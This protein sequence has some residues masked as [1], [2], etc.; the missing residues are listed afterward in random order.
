MYSERTLYGGMRVL[1][2]TKDTPICIIVMSD[3]GR[4][5][6]SFNYFILKLLSTSLAPGKRNRPPRRFC[7]L[8][9]DFF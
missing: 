6:F 2:R 9:R 8:K 1:K 7:Y 3:L 5:R 4:K